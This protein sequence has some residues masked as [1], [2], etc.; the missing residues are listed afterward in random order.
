MR[1]TRLST[2]T[3]NRQ[4]QQIAEDLSGGYLDF[5]AG[6]RPDSPD[7]SVSD[8]FRL[9]RNQFAAIAFGAPKNGVL[10]A[11]QI[12]KSV[13]IKKGEPT[14]CRCL[15]KDGEIVMDGTVGEEN[16]NAIT[17]V[18]TLVKGQIV[19][20]TEFTYTVNKQGT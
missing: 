7:D 6:D 10:K 3:A 11:N 1:N 13:A 20:V 8:D 16:A 2:R 5:M 15:T 4:A 17:K 14:W 19:S 12:A 9:S 18:E